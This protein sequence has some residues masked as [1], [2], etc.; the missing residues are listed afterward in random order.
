M[1]LRKLLFI[2]ISLC[3]FSVFSGATLVLQPEVVPQVLNGKS[4]IAS[5]YEK[6]NTLKLNT[7]ENQLAITI[8]QI[9]FEDG[10]RRKFDSQ[11]L[12]LSFFVQEGDTLSI[13]YDKFRTID[14]ANQFEHNPI[15]TVTHE[16][17]KDKKYSL[18]QL[19]KGGLQGFRDY[20]REVTDYNLK[21]RNIG[22]QQK[23]VISPSLQDN[24][25][26]LQ[27]EFSALT[28]EQQQVFMQWAMRNLK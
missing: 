28:S 11:P 1:F 20:Q 4:I 25:T 26:I 24:I 8:G 10:K 17:G 9:V 27:S 18:V 19:N 12:L 7:G 5:N 6:K 23:T 2:V 13:Q 16:N 15:L 21:N 3:S 14:E 22:N